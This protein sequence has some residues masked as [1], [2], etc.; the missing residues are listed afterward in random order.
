[1]LILPSL[2]IALIGVLM[3]ALSANPK[4]VQIGDRMFFAGILAALLQLGP[5]MAKL[6]PTAA[7]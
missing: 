3:F 5:Q 4:L 1:M 2:L 7:G 6:F